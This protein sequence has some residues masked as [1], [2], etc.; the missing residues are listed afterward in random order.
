LTVT[1]AQVTPQPAGVVFNYF[2]ECNTPTA[3][4]LTQTVSMSGSPGV[5]YTA[6]IVNSPDMA[7]AQAA[8]TGPIDR[9]Y[10]NDQ[11][12]L[13]IRDAT[14]HEATVGPVGPREVSASGLESI[15][16]SG[17]PWL[18]ASSKSD[19]IPDTITLNA[20][21]KVSPSVE[22]KQALLVIVADARAG[23]PPDNVRLVPVMML[24]TRSQIKL[25]MI[26]R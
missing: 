7:T 19:I 24:C 20:D 14:G 4:I 22:F 25:P 26:A 5:R 18:K 15:W 17:A 1:G 21:P 11:G 10:I 3:T 6:A 13:I 2:G 16:P 23:V 8:L 9:G 12:D